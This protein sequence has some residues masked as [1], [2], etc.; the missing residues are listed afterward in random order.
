MG[1]LS[2][3]SMRT[4][5]YVFKSLAYLRKWIGIDKT[6]NSVQVHRVDL[7]PL[8]HEVSSSS[9]LWRVRREG[10]GQAASLAYPSVSGS[11]KQW[12]TVTSALLEQPDTPDWW[13]ASTGKYF[14]LQWGSGQ[15]ALQCSVG[16]VGGI[17]PGC[18]TGVPQSKAA[19]V[20]G[21]VKECQLLDAA[22]SKCQSR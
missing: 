2:L 21:C 12:V 3:R 15:P 16:T 4:G 20:A 9:Q 17:V 11:W 22:D 13:R 1:S 5:F 19:W 7:I 18:R 14:Q 8:M 6:I 10:G